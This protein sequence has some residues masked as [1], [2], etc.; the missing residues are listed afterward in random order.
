VVAEALV[1]ARQRLPQ[2]PLRPYTHTIQRAI[3]RGEIRDQ[4]E[5]ARML[6]V[7]RARMTQVLDLTLLAP[8]IQEEILFMDGL[9]RNGGDAK[10]LRHAA[11]L[12]AWEEQKAVL[13][14]IGAPRQLRRRA[15]PPGRPSVA[16]IAASTAS[17]SRGE[18]P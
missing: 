2:F 14:T 7:T 8:A 6:G 1:C 3:D 17:I 12:S 18:R 11:R 10:H 15:R 16:D 13:V 9:K 4:A 5:A